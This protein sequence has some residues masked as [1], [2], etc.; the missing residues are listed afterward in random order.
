MPT[1]TTVDIGSRVFVI[2]KLYWGAGKRECDLQ[3]SSRRAAAACSGQHGGQAAAAAAT[4]ATTFRTFGDDGGANVERR[5]S[6]SGFWLYL[7]PN[8]TYVSSVRSET[9]AKLPFSSS[10]LFDFPDT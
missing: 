7:S 9:G 5:G 8:I 2:N 1:R 3:R 4:A 10:A 6:K